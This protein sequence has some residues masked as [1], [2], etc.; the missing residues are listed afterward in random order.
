MSIFFPWIFL[1]VCLF[2]YSR[3]ANVQV[4]KK[5]LMWPF[6]KVR[7]RLLQHKLNEIVIVSAGRDFKSNRKYTASILGSE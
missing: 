4:A 7:T 2:V 5:K 1:F 6:P 3:T